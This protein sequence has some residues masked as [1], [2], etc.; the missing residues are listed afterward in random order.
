MANMD[1]EKLLALL[2]DSNE[3]AK[4]CNMTHERGEVT[5]FL[6]TMIKQLEF[7]Q[8]Q[9]R[10]KRMERAYGAIGYKPPGQFQESLERLQQSRQR[11]NNTK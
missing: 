11:L 9:E 7:Q 6:Q 1:N 3:K 10:A 5:R 2:H 4:R 8:A